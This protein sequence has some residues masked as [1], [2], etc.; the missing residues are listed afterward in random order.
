MKRHVYLLAL[1][2]SAIGCGEADVISEPQAQ[3]S[4]PAIEEKRIPVQI[5]RSSEGWMTASMTD[6]EAIALRTAETPE[7]TQTPAGWYSQIVLYPPDYI[8]N[9]C[10][11]YREPGSAGAIVVFSEANYGG[12]CAEMKFSTDYGTQAFFSGWAMWYMA[13]GWYYW[14]DDVSSWKARARSNSYYRIVFQEHDNYGARTEFYIPP[15]WVWG[16]T[17]MSLPGASR[18]IASVTGQPI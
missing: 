4:P 3:P 7:P 11:S 14:N 5:H 15:Y 1:V 18:V 8:V 2:A 16:E 10:G 13:G 12:G 6:A 17:N 9:D